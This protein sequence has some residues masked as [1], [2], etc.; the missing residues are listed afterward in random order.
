MIVLAGY[1]VVTYRKSRRALM[2][3]PVS[4]LA[5]L[6]GERGRAISSLAPSGTVRVSGETWAAESASG[7]IEPGGHVVVISQDRLRLTVRSAEP[8]DS[9][10]AR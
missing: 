1:G 7:D 3:P 9:Q 6:V 4:G 5:S 8:P 2:A 10:E